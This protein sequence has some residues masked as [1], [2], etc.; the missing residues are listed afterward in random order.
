MATRYLN[1]TNGDAD[2]FGE[3]TEPAG[4]GTAS[5]PRLAHLPCAVWHSTLPRAAATERRAA[6]CG[7]GR[8]SLETASLIDHVP[9]VTAPEETP[10]GW[11][12]FFDGLDPAEAARAP[13]RAQSDRPFARP[14]EHGD[15]VHEVL[16]TTLTRRVARP[17]APRRT[18][19]G[20]RPQQRQPRAHPHRIRPGLTASLCSTT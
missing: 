13:D 7:Q 8:L 1:C 6:H 10:R 20:A 16:M 11:V 9:Y 5:R 4:R 2:A 17:D 3:F 12:P 18:R 14:P 15:D 19:Y